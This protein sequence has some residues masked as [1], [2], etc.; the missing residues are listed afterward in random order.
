MSDLIRSEWRRFRR[1]SLIVALCH[2][3]GLLLMYAAKR[4]MPK[5]VLLK[6]N[7]KERSLEKAAGD[8]DRSTL[9]E[10]I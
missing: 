2:G 5:K 3:F 9:P 10:S 8:A 7:P 6:L 1:L 4:L